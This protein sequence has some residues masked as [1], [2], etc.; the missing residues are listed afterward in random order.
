[1]KVNQ[2]LKVVFSGSL[3]DNFLQDIIQNNARKLAIEGTV[4]MV[5]PTQIHIIACG[6]KEKIDKF[7]D[8]LHEGV[9]AIRAEDIIIEPFLKIKDYRGVFRIIE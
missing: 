9:A 6:T 3:P 4:Q 5:S 7:L 2:C 1:M 8:L